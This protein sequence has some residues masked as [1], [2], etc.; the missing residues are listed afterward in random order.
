MNNTQDGKQQSVMSSVREFE[1]KAKPKVYISYDLEAYQNDPTLFTLTAYVTNLGEG[2][3][4]GVYVQRTDHAGN[5]I[6]ICGDQRQFNQR[7]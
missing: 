1:V 6:Q 2:A 3:A 7:D 5:R 4:E